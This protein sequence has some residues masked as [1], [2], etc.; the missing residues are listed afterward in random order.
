MKNTPRHK[1]RRLRQLSNRLEALA[2]DIQFG[3]A[4]YEN[5]QT[6]VNSLISAARILRYQHDG[7]VQTQLRFKRNTG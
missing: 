4:Y 3:A 2:F 1:A 6:D 7:I 5:K